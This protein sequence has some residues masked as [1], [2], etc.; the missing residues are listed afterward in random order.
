[1]LAEKRK[2]G[3]EL[4]DLT[5]ANPTEA[6]AA[7][8]HSKIRDAYQAI[9]D[10]VYQ[11]NPLGSIKAREAIVQWYSRRGIKVSAQ[12]LALTA[13]SSEAYSLLFKT[14][15][16]PGEE[17]LFPSPSYPLFEYLA[18]VESVKAIPYRLQYDGSWFI[19]F[20]SLRDAITTRSRAIVIVNPNNPTGSFVKRREL[21][22]LLNIAK[23]HSLPV[24]SD[25]VFMD[26]ALIPD[27][28][29]APTLIGQD[30]VLNFSLNG[31]SKSA[32]MPQMKLGWIA[33]NGPLRERA[34]TMERLELFLDTFLSV[35]TPVQ[36]AL[37]GLLNVGEEVRQSISLRVSV[38]NEALPRLL[39]NTPIHHLHGEGGWSAIL[40]LPN[41]LTEEIWIA[42]LL[43]EHGVIVQ[44]GYFFDMP[45]E[46]FVVVSLITEPADFIR[47]I[48]G[49]QQMVCR[50]ARAS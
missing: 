7:Y 9:P 4:L 38:N 37:A 2:S 20:E 45:G 8:P 24:I 16:N 11:P 14:L 46:P 28:D 27:P 29:R 5:L 48:Y 26:Y 18:S 39:N 3:I 49:L 22:E 6:L 15:C 23:E 31:L 40:Q 19:D 13:S 50:V 33:V 32:G 34:E 47:G 25:E 10:F 35:G 42:R 1:M 17:V 12:Q 30:D 44:P 36:N 21:G 41:I 43:N